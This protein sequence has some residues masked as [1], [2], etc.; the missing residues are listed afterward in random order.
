MDL[1]DALE[2]LD[3]PVDVSN[4]WH[5]DGVGVSSA[6]SFLRRKVS[7]IIQNMRHDE[8]MNVVVGLKGDVQRAGRRGIQRQLGGS[9]SLV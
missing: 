4:F 8:K 5:Y 7:G 1:A 3:R 2:D 9:L 6:F